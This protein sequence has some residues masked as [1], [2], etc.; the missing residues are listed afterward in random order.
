MNG[1]ACS[2]HRRAY[3]NTYCPSQSRC[4]FV[5]AVFI[6]KI[7]WQLYC[8]IQSNLR[9]QNFICRKS[10]SVVTH[11]MQAINRNYTHTSWVWEMEKIDVEKGRKKAAFVELSKKCY[12]KSCFLFTISRTLHVI[13]VNFPLRQN[14]R[15]CHILH[16]NS[17]N[18]NIRNK[19]RAH[20]YPLIQTHTERHRHW[21]SHNNTSSKF[22]HIHARTLHIRVVFNVFIRSTHSKNI[23]WWYYTILMHAHIYFIVSS[24]SLH[25]DSRR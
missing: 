12:I 22:I 21:Q 16:S 25:T 15:I 8:F 14:K 24:P 1:G 9:K 17:G 3:I 23:Y 10:S 18:T 19:I 2:A 11:L 13:C 7:H 5:S 4:S 6:K 20:T